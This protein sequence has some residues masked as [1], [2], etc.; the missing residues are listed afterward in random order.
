MDATW[1]SDEYP[2]ILIHSFTDISFDRPWTLFDELEPLTVHY[3][4][5][6]ALQG[7]AW[8]QGEEQLSS[9]ATA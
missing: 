7:F 3:D 5:G 2:D 6:I 4:G 8:G 1:G 9:E